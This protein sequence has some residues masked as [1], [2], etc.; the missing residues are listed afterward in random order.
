MIYIYLVKYR[1]LGTK[2]VLSNFKKSLTCKKYLKN[3]IFGM[4][5]RE[6][7]CCSNDILF[8]QSLKELKEVLLK[9]SYPQKL[10]DSK[11][12]IFMSDDQKPP[13][14]ERVHT[15][16]LDFTAFSLEPYVNSLLKKM[17]KVVPSFHVNVAYKSVPVSSLFSTNSKAVL[18]FEKTP[19]V[20]YEFT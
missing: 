15:L 10:I 12:R 13:R 20:Y 5:H 2:T 6:R 7:D 1:K 14:P 8:K 11:I 18:P 17:Q 3:A 9:N 16:N 19:N 4:L